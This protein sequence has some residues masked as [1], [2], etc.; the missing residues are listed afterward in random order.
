MKLLIVR[1]GEAEPMCKADAERQLTE[2][3]VADALAL[4]RRLQQAGLKPAKAAVSPYQ[5]AQQ[6][7]AAIQR[8]LA[9]P[10]VTIE[11]I[12]PESS[13][14]QAI[15]ALETV[16]DGCDYL[17]MVSHLPLVSSL[18]AYLVDGSQRAAYEYPMPPASLAELELDVIAPG[19]AT[20]KRLISPPYGV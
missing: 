1:H 13:V 11:H 4:G 18:I 7:F 6:T 14:A 8:A 5:R 19:C 20:L 16:A 9:I 3:G 2:K 15:V 17:L 10:A 12:T